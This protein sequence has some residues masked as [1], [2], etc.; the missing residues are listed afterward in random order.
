ML[1]AFSLLL[2]L[3]PGW[4]EPGA[5]E[6]GHAA[7]EREQ[8]PVPGGRREAWTPNFCR[9]GTAVSLATLGADLSAE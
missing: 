3:T 8:S 9:A 6:G 1:G 2:G 7:W 5:F 4:R